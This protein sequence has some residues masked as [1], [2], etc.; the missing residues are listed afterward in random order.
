MN[1]SRWIRVTQHKNV[2]NWFTMLVDA[3]MVET[4]WTSALDMNPWQEI[5]SKEIGLGTDG[6]SWESLLGVWAFFWQKAEVPRGWKLV[7]SAGNILDWWG[8][9]SVC[10]LLGDMSCLDKADNQGDGKP[11]VWVKDSEL[12]SWKCGLTRVGLMPTKLDGESYSN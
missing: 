10:H 4:L 6:L 11:S 2:G 12:L 5:L 1:P 7:L 8:G 9:F 3:S